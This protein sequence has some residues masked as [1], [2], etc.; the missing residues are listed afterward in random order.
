ME[1]SITAAVRLPEETQMALSKQKRVQRINNEHF[2]RVHPELRG[3]ISAFISALLK[4]KPDDVDLFAEN[5]FTQPDLAH[6]LGYYGW[7]R[8]PTPEP[9]EG[10]LEDSGYEGEEMFVDDEEEAG[11]GGGTTQF[12][13][14]QLE[15]TLI[16]LFKE[17]DQDNSGTLEFAEFAQLMATASIGLN[18]SELQLLLAEADENSDGLVTYQ[19]FVPLAVEVIQTM[20]LKERIDA[21]EDELDEVFRDA[22]MNSI[23]VSSAEVESMVTKKVNDLGGDGMVTR[24]QLK[25]LLKS[26]QLGLSKQQASMAAALINF[27][28][29]GAIDAATLAP[30][31][32]GILV[33]AI[34]KALS[35]QNLGEVAAEVER[36]CEFFDKEKTGFLD[37]PLL[38]QAISS[39]FNFLTRLQINSIVSD[40]RAPT[41]E[42][43]QVCW[44]E[45][46]PRLSTMI[47]AMGD[48]EAIR[49]RA[50]LAARAEYQP[51]ALMSGH[52]QEQFF[53]MMKGLFEEADTDKNGS[54][55]RKEFQKCMLEA[56]LGLSEVDIIDLFE[57]FDED[58]S[59]EL[60][61]NEFLT[62]GYDVISDLARERAI[63]ELMY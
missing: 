60:D 62:G 9:L 5:F 44:R 20:R 53:A 56:D 12:S 38:K 58:G 31:L 61:M 59:G 49:E 3:M 15:Q 43:G 13:V 37:P 40:S 55:D 34:A 23:G 30:T 4:Q 25:G 46:L 8:P 32:H 36:L 27:D 21:E 45:Y 17:A 24:S 52:E 11:G 26:P 48:P 22:A 28:A 2:F 10:E 6:Q 47:K 1:G 39:G 63:N 51:A 33:T 50:E 18:S 57:M 14:Q 35:M 41:N 19:E 29:N 42:A 16:S 7:T 54:L